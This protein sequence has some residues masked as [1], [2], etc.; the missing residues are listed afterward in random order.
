LFLCFRRL[1]HGPL[2]HALV[3]LRAARLGRFLRDLFGLEV[4]NGDDLLLLPG[5][6]YRAEREQSEQQQRF[7][8]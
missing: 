1:R 8:Q 7:D 2:L 5:L 3:A 4:Y 6:L